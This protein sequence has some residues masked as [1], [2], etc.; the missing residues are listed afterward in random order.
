[1]ELFIMSAARE[2]REGLIGTEAGDQARRGE[3]RNCEGWGVSGGWVPW[4]E[5]GLMPPTHSQGF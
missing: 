3:L 2:G 1:M 5:G 4:G